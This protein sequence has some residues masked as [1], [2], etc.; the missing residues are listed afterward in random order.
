ME[1]EGDRQMMIRR[2]Q[3]KDSSD[4]AMG[5]VMTMTMM[6]M[7]M[8]AL[9]LMLMLMLMLLMLMLI[10]LMMM[11]M[12]MMVMMMTMMM[13]TRT[14]TMMMMMMLITTGIMRVAASIESLTVVD[15]ACALQ[16]AF[17]SEQGTQK[18]GAPSPSYCES[19]ETVVRFAAVLKVGQGR[20]VCN[21]YTCLTGPHFAILH[22]RHKCRCRDAWVAQLHSDPSQ[23][24]HASQRCHAVAVTFNSFSVH[25]EQCLDEITCLKWEVPFLV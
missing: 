20:Y 17:E 8:L 18:E 23:S 6:M 7:M 21:C 14:M 13:M 11:V 4:Q 3:D 22:A 24:C 12:M 9:V 2:L 15:N 19:T 10:R 25:F 1:G 5:A 16:P